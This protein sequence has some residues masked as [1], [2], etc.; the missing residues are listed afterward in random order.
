MRE[1]FSLVIFT[2]VEIQVNNKIQQPEILVGN[3]IYQHL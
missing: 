2:V 1:A 3:S